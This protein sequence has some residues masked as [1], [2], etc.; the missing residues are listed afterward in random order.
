MIQEFASVYVASTVAVFI[1]V[2]VDVVVFGGGIRGSGGSD[3]VGSLVVVVVVVVTRILF[4]L[5]CFSLFLVAELNS[6]I[7]CPY[8]IYYIHT[9][10]L[11][12][13]SFYS[14]F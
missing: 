7:V 3:G 10:C 11:I 2:L 13:Y 1:L 4:F 14:P 8:L 12:H 5:F 9:S 6:K